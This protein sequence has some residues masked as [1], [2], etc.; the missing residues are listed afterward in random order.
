[1]KSDLIKR[2]KPLDIIDDVCSYETTSIKKGNN[3]IRK[4][5]VIENIISSDFSILSDKNNRNIVVPCYL[6]Y[7]AHAY[8]AFSQ[9]P[10]GIKLNASLI[11]QDY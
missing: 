8:V 5:R 2:I 10:P 4:R 6:Q 3:Q 9:A 11:N 7:V 1:M